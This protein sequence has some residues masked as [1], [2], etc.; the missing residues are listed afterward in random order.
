MTCQKIKRTVLLTSNDA[1]EWRDIKSLTLTDLI[2][3]YYYYYYYYFVNIKKNGTQTAAHI[4]H[5]CSAQVYKND[6]DCIL[7]SSDYYFEL[8]QYPS[9]PAREDQAFY[10][11]FFAKL[12]KNALTERKHID[13]EER[14]RE[15]EKKNHRLGSLL[16]QIDNPV[17]PPSHRL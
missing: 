11:W 17:C 5:S 12:S 13:G 9:P 4:F 3:Y 2:Y 1:Y 7:N 16:A 8:R 14:E 6:D 15:R 10:H